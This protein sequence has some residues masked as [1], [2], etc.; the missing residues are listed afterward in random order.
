MG[1]FYNS[2]RPLTMPGVQCSLLDA[3]KEKGFLS[4]IE[5]NGVARME[6]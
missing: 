6:T 5:A 1:D 3:E 4:S 2:P